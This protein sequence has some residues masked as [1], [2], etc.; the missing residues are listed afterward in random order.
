MFKVEGWA[1]LP[2]K[3]GG[4]SPIVRRYFLQ[5]FGVLLWLASYLPEQPQR[6]AEH[7]SPLGLF[8]Y[9]WVWLLLRLLPVLMLVQNSQ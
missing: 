4:P 6:A 9:L 5:P 2:R 3:A 1:S 7:H 8:L